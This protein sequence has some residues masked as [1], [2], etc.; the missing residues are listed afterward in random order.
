MW[1]SGQSQWHQGRNSELCGKPAK[2]GVTKSGLEGE[3]CLIS[4]I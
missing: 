3:K 1:V 4:E 2:G